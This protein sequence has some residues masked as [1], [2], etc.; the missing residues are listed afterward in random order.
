MGVSS[1]RV[2]APSSLQGTWGV[3]YRENGWDMGA[4]SPPGPCAHTQVPR[5][6]LTVPGRLPSS[7]KQESLKTKPKNAFVFLPEDCLED[8]SRD[9]GSSTL[10]LSLRSSSSSTQNKNH[11]D[12]SLGQLHP[13]ACWEHP[14]RTLDGLRGKQEPQVSVRAL[15]FHHLCRGRR[16]HRTEMPNEHSFWSRE[17]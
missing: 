9:S 13:R 15:R 14:T 8:T 7:E 17:G 12:L 16:A 4:A 5:A 1:P 2:S 6:G 3:S 11:A 10:S